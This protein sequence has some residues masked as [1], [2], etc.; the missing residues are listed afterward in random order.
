MKTAA[1][2]KLASLGEPTSQSRRVGTGYT[3]MITSETI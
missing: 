1:S 3:L 2:V